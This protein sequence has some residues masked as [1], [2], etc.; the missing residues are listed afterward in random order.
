MSNCSCWLLYDY[1]DYLVN[2]EYVSLMQKWAK[3]KGVEVRPVIKESITLGISEKG[4]PYC[5]LDN[6]IQKPDIL[7]SRQRDFRYS[8]HFE[9]MGVLVMNNSKVCQIANDKWQTY[10]FLKNTPMPSTK[11]GAKELPFSTPFILKPTS[12]HGGK[13]VSV[14]TNQGIWESIETKPIELPWLTQKQM[15]D[16]QDLR[17]YILFGEIVGAVKRKAK[18]GI[19]S[20]FSLGGKVH[21]H[22]LT[23]EEKTLTDSIIQQF[24]IKNAPLQF[25]GIDFLYNEG[26]PILNEVEDVVGSRM[27]YQSSDIDIVKLFWENNPYV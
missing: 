5:I 4:I 21:L 11:I 17:V 6:C 14:I 16:G 24:K 13:D 20:N 22:T 27:L 3:I 26:K 1:R 7:L 8:M 18:K 9:Q 25:A 23:I 19:I 12:G 10:Q 2:K 15:D